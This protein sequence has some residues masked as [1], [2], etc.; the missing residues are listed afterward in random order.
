M[1]FNKNMTGNCG[2]D[3][4]GWRQRHVAESCKHFST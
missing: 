3:I 4:Y 2:L 1:D